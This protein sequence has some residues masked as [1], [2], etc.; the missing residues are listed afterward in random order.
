MNLFLS[1]DSYYEFSLNEYYLSDL[2]KYAKKNIDISSKETIVDVRDT[3]INIVDK[4]TV[5]HP[6]TIKEKP[7][8]SFDNSEEDN[9][10]NDESVK[11]EKEGFEQI[12]IFDDLDE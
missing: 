10:E 9:D 3:T 7:P 1:N 11:E 8:I 12:S 5:S 4:K 6:I 2:D